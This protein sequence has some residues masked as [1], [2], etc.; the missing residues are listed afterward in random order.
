[1]V[2]WIIRACFALV[3]IGLGLSLA[4]N[5]QLS[6]NNRL[7]VFV[8]FFLGT[9]ITIALDATIKKKRIDLIT[10]IYFGILVGLFLT[11]VGGLVLSPLFESY[12]ESFDAALAANEEP[13]M[14]PE[15]FRTVI[16]SFIVAASHALQLC[17]SLL[18]LTAVLV[19]LFCVPLRGPDCGVGGR[20]WAAT[21]LG[22]L[23]ESYPDCAASRAF[24]QKN[25]CTPPRT[26]R[27]WRCTS[28]WP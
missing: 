26:P 15:T 16:V 22:H 25:T 13:G 18:Q 23:M 5:T 28:A 2:L 8:L 12:K 24:D 7:L 4:L 1:M 21:N 11:Y 6:G 17:K 20:C 27:T 19:G 14:T 10:S 9:G 3:A